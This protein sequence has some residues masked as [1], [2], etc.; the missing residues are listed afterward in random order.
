MKSKKPICNEI[1]KAT[2]IDMI[3]ALF[4]EYFI[5]TNILI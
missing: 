2:D 4:M 3:V 1:R 5:K